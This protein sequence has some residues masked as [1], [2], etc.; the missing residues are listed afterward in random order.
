MVLILTALLGKI[1]YEEIKDQREIKK[2]KAEQRKSQQ[3]SSPS[4]E[5]MMSYQRVS[6]E[7][8]PE[9]R[10]YIEPPIPTR[11]SATFS[12]T[13]T[14]FPHATTA[15]SP[16]TSSSS[17]DESPIE[18]VFE[19]DACCRPPAYDKELPLIPPLRV[20]V[21]GSQVPWSPDDVRARFEELGV[22]ERRAQESEKVFELE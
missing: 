19:M 4:T 14:K 17:F 22:E 10:N 6:R 5:Q 9:Q 21:R 12:P 16:T 2:A 18:G 13:T 11:K 3:L 7:L 1:I 8:N 20:N 15:T